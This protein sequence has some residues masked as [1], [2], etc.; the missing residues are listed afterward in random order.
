MLS[1]IEL[2]S[3]AQVLLHPSSDF[4]QGV[5][6][7][8]VG[9]GASLLTLPVFLWPVAIFALPPWSSGQG[10]PPCKGGNPGSPC[11]PPALHRAP[12]PSGPSHRNSPAACPAF[13]GCRLLPSF[14]LT[15]AAF[16]TDPRKDLRA[17]TRLF[18]PV[19][20][21]H[22]RQLLSPSALPWSSSLKS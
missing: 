13:S 2:S 9:G 14:P 3:R 21:A 4:T 16:H 7:P 11:W 12:Q 18:P 8:C 15:H 20:P 5:L 22:P 19:I 6:S 10:R 1:V 17:S